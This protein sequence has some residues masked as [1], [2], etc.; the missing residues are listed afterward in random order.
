MLPVKKIY[1]DTKYRTANS[2]SSSNFKYE[3]PYCVTLPEHT[4]IHGILLNLVLM[5]SYI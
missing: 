2:V 1:V 5:I 3:L 4:A